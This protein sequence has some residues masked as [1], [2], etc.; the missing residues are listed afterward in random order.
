MDN[1]KTIQKIQKLAD[2]RKSAKVIKFLES[3]DK[4]V[5]EAALNALCQIQDEDS[6]NTAA[7]L[8]DNSDPEIRIAAA[9]A[10]GGIGTEYVKTYLQHR[11]TTEQDEDVKKA[12]MEA[13]HTIAVNRA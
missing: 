12:I 9:K 11:M 13:L 1:T 2:K 10:L 4:E 6:V 5:V 8:I 3:S 7:H